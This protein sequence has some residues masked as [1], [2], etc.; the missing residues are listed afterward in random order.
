M[1]VPGG[2]FALMGCITTGWEGILHK[3]GV[4][5]LIPIF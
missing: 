2:C 4:L 5:V 1:T 3:L